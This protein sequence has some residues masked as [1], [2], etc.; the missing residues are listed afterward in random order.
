MTSKEPISYLWDI[1]KHK[2]HFGKKKTGK[3]TYLAFC[4]S[5]VGDCFD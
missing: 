2:C 5:A 3:V 1:V 4:F